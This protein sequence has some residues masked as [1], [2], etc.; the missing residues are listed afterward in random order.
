MPA[1]MTKLPALCATLVA[2]FGMTA[3]GVE[4]IAL[5]HAGNHYTACRVDPAREQLRIFHRDETGKAFHDFARLE[6]W[7][8]ARSNTLVFAMNGGMFRP[9]FQP[10]GLLIENGRQ[11]SPLNLE[12][13]DGNFFLLPNGVFYVTERSAAVV[14]STAFPLVQDNIR[15]ANQ[16]GPLL[17][18]KGR[19]HPAFRAESASKLVRNGV[20]VTAAG[21]VIFVISEDA[22][23]LHTFAVLF[24]D[25]LECPNAL[26][27]DG[28][29]SGLHAPPLKRSDNRA[30][31][32]PIIG[33]TE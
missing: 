25:K 4:F 7:I 14:E 33:I 32:G 22:V 18:N 12:K 27:L 30:K 29:I 5:E 8:A 23:N 20:G 15:M 17:L 1:R 19:V 9:D 3:R 2:L 11:S 16:S 28:V 6:S 24:R 13:G 10:V 21:A 31:L 26:Y